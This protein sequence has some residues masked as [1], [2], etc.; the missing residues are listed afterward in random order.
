MLFRSA[1]GVFSNPELQALFDKLVAQGKT[2][3]VE[4][5][6]VG[7]FIEE[8]DIADL[9]ARKTTKA[10]INLV[11][12]NLERGSRNHLRSFMNNLRNRGATYTPSQLPATEFNQIASGGI[13]RGQ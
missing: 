8:L 11:Y 4:A 13:E 2:S 5:L 3:E 7:A 9:Q 1:E 6:K 10:D 12:Q